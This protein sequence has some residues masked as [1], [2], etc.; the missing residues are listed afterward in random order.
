MEVLPVEPLDQPFSGDSG[1]ALA[2]PQ[3][4]MAS[5]AVVG[6]LLGRPA[7]IQTFDIGGGFQGAVLL[8][9]AGTADHPGSLTGS[10]TQAGHIVKNGLSHGFG[11]L[12]K[13][14]SADYNCRAGI[15]PAAGGGW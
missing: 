9:G 3:G 12:A 4:Y 7:I 2:R 11:V 8:R 10:A 1:A 6:R 13:G 15:R 5:D 14:K